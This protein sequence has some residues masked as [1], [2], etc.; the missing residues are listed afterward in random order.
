MHSLS[1]ISS[2]RNW[3][4]H[5]AFTSLLTRI[6]SECR[7]VHNGS[8]TDFLGCCYQQ[9]RRAQVLKSSV[10]LPPDQTKQ[11]LESIDFFVNLLESLFP[12]MAYA[13]RLEKLVKL[14][15]KEREW[16]KST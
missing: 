16:E 14:I 5:A 3:K 2:E 6:E 8:S 13:E 11:A 12:A 9:K 15:K 4:L 10:Q 7:G 1:F